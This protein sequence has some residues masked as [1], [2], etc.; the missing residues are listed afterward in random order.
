MTLS[1][2]PDISFNAHCTVKFKL[3]AKHPTCR[4]LHKFIA[5]VILGVLSVVQAAIRFSK[6][7]SLTTLNNSFFKLIE[8]CDSKYLKQDRK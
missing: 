4:Q 3:C 8:V 6:P 1:Y 2:V 7:H 5:L